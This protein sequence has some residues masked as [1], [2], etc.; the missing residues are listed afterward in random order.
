MSLEGSTADLILG[1]ALAR[2]SRWNLMGIS[3]PTICQE[4]NIGSRMPVGTLWSDIST[5]ILQVRN[6][7]VK[8]G[9]VWVAC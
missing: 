7:R 5:H 6:L 1:P 2:A 3:V 9:K 8:E 4:L